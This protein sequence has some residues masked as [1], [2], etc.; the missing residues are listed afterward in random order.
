MID[1]DYVI[2]DL[3]NVDPSPIAPRVCNCDCGHTFQP[4]RSDQ[5]YINKRHADKAYHENIRKPQQENQKIIESFMRANDRV[6]QKYYNTQN[7]NEVV[8]LLEALKANGF[9]SSY[10][11][12]KTVIGKVE[13]YLTYNFAINFFMVNEIEKVKI[14]KQ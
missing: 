11:L 14:R 13:Y 2:K 8:C 4:K 12:G 5:I 9:N 7:G 3:N 10:F 6:C 1:N